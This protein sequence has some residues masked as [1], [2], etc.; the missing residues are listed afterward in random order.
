MLLG[1]CSANSLDHALV[2]SFS[3]QQNKLTSLGDPW[4]ILW[5][6]PQDENF[7]A[8]AGTVGAV[9]VAGSTRNDADPSSYGRDVILRKYTSE[10][11]LAWNHTWRTSYDEAAFGLAAAMDALY[12]AGQTVQDDDN[13]NGLLMKLNFNGNPIWNISWGTNTTECFTSIAI[14]DGV[15]VSGYRQNS[16][17]NDVDAVL[18]KFDF[19]GDELW[20][21][22]W[23]GDNVDYGSDVAV[24]DDG[25][26]LVGWTSLQWS[27]T[28]HNTFLTK[29]SPS[30]VQIWNATWGGSGDDSGWGV[31]IAN[32]SIFVTGETQSYSSGSFSDIALLKYNSS[33][34]LLWNI[35]DSAGFF[36]S[37]Y[38]LINSSDS[39]YLAGKLFDP[40]VGWRSSLLHFDING[41]LLWKRYWGGAGNC[42]PAALAHSIN[43]LYIAGTTY[44]WLTDDPNGFLVKYSF[45]GSS[46][47]GPI[48]LSD[49]ED[50]DQDGTF[51]VSWTEALDPD[52]TITGYELQ[53]ARSPIFSWY[54][55]TWT[56]TQTTFTVNDR[57]DG[58]Y[59][60]RV[61]A[62]DNASLY[63]PWSNIQGI[64][65]TTIMTPSIN[66]WL[67]LIIL[68]L[69]AGIMAV[70][71]LVLVIRRWRIE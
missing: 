61:R 16:S 57:T 6:G 71:L 18:T 14:G 58:F 20:N 25:V 3:F 13:E 4:G 41:T 60:F 22:T 63:G 1:I 53:M 47:P 52:G 34:S 33:G 7:S 68:A 29:F 30:G 50:I 65:V 28:S 31:T 48:E 44:D 36:Q 59:Y 11:E 40:S 10:G 54:N 24:A 35:T 15:Y 37:G 8:V 62:R 69:G 21:V 26:Y 56:T 39:I 55:I 42:E 70:I 67:A 51:V 45:D 32:K 19:N 2:F 49:V 46:A 17:I 66:P 12:L 43:G 38:N 5:M 27:G 23:N 64:N 9:F